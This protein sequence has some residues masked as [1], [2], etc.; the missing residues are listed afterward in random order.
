M[1]TGTHYNRV[2]KNRMQRFLKKLSLNLLK[3]SDVIT[4]HQL[5]TQFSVPIPS[6]Q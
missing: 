4:I 5:Y 1:A 3:S 2:A 6:L